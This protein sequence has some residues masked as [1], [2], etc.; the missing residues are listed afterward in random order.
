MQGDD[1]DKPI[2]THQREK[3]IKNT[4]PGL[5]PKFVFEDKM[6]SDRDQKGLKELQFIFHGGLKMAVN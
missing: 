1:T 3:E 6:T 4:N 5:A 2:F